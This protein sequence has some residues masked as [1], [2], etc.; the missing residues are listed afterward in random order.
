VDGIDIY[1]RIKRDDKGYH[2]CCL[3][4]FD[5][6]DYDARQWMCDADGE[7]KRF[8]S[9]ADAEDWLRTTL[10]DAALV[11]IENLTAYRVRQRDRHAAKEL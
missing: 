7:P 5:E 9:E 1:Y 3:Q 6:A 10:T 11:A 2:V 8:E 4:W